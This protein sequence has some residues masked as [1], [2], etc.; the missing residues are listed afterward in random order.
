MA[1]D[2]AFEAMEKVRAL[3]PGLSLLLCRARY[4]ANTELR[5][6][7]PFA[8][9]VWSMRFALKYSPLIVHLLRSNDTTT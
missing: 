4:L 1:Q 6:S 3:L 8:D 5:V 2:A 7:C 9:V